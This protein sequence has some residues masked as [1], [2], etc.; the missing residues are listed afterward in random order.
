MKRIK[1]TIELEFVYTGDL[2]DPEKILPGVFDITHSA[3]GKLHN[4][5]CQDA[6]LCTNAKPIYKLEEIK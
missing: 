3:A 5:C 4:I 1:L 6:R 2:K